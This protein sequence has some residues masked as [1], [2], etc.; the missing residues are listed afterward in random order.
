MDRLK[1][2][3]NY[4]LKRYYAG[5]NYINNHPDEAEKYIKNVLGF[6]DKLNE[7]IPKIKNMTINEILN[8]F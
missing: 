8:G 2:E 5:V 6:L 1:E 3:Y 7:I 4:Y